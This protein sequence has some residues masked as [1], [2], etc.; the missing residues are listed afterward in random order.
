M[1]QFHG[2]KQRDLELPIHRKRL[3]NH[4][5]SDLTQDRNVKAIFYGGSLG[6]GNTDMFSDIDL[7]IVVEGS[8]VQEYR[9]KKKER[10]HHWGNILFFEGYEHESFI[11]AH[12]DSFI[13]ADIFYYEESDLMPS[14]WLQDLHIV[15]DPYNIVNKVQLRSNQLQYQFS[16]EDVEAWRTKHFA[17]LHEVYRRAAR[18][19]CYYAMHC[20]DCLRLSIVTGWYMEMGIQPNSFGDWAKI[21]G[22]R[23]PLKKWQ[24][25]RL[26]RWDSSGQLD[27][28][29]NVIIDMKPEFERVNKHL[30]VS[31]GAS[32]K[33]DLVED[34]YRKIL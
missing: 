17:F 22:E 12:F 3:M 8:K 24:L 31:V 14:V 15:Y 29:I 28:V 11:I 16:I 30:S 9:D 2:H 4:I 10:A 20:L 18:G 5:E 19:E 27:E 23:S 7:R 33:E 13:K 32:A 21:E 26:Q 34:I 25:E 6:S 1:D